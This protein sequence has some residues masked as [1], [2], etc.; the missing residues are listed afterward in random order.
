MKT[1]LS[2]I[3]AVALAIFHYEGQRPGNRNYR[4]N[5][6]GNLR[7]S[8]V[9]HSMDPGNYCIF[10]SF[11]AGFTALTEDLRAKFR[12]NNSHGLGPSSTLLDLFN[13]YAPSSDNNVPEKYAESVAA[14]LSE[15]YGK[16]L[17]VMVTLGD[18]MNLGGLTQ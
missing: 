15:A 5:N 12:G 11:V 2:P 9:P 13:T 18:V 16:P 3:D 17:T 14:W 10:A 1:Y 7:D 6:P 8:S 4:N